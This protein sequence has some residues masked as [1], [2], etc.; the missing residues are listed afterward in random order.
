VDFHVMTALV[1]FLLPLAYSPGPG[2]AF[3]AS[4]GASHGLRAAIPALLGYHAATFV[5]TAMIGM[6]AGLLFLS[7]PRAS[8]ILAI[9][10]A[11]YVFWLGYLFLK[12]SKGTQAGSRGSGALLRIGFVD[13]ALILLFNP[14]A[15]YIIGLLFTQFLVPPNVGLAAVLSITA[16][17]TLNNLVAFLVWTLAGAAI[18]RLFTSDAANRRINI[19]FALCLIGVGVWMLIPVLTS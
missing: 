11:A 16:I 10:G 6:G 1:I 17:F 12:A 19:F 18:A 5:V 4:I 8:R 15:Y 7:E 3:F 14:K 9:L 13:G 2:N